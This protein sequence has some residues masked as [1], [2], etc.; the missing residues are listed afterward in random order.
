MTLRS[1]KTRTSNSRCKPLAIGSHRAWL[2]PQ[3]SGRACCVLDIIETESQYRYLGWG[4]CQ[5]CEVRIWKKLRCLLRPKFRSEQF[6][7]RTTETCPR[8]EFPPVRS[9]SAAS[10]PAH[11]ANGVLEVCL[12]AVR[13]ATENVY[14]CSVI[15]LLPVFYRCQALLHAWRS[16]L[17]CLHRFTRRVSHSA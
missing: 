10:G 16:C 5:P 6:N 1:S 14:S 17:V 15:G 13:I 11:S 2:A 9:S 7:E 8:S 4:G 3:K 12:A